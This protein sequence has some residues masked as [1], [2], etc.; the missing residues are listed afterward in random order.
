MG[1]K[2]DKKKGKVDVTIQNREVVYGDT[3]PNSK[4]RKAAIQHM[5]KHYTGGR[6]VKAYVKGKMPELNENVIVNYLIA[7]EFATSESSAILIMRHMSDE[8][9]AHVICES[10]GNPDSAA[11]AVALEKWRKSIEAG[12]KEARAKVEPTSTKR[13]KPTKR[14][15]QLSKVQ[16]R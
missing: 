12:E 8:W 4:A 3:P 13:Y 16:I 6:A 11:M 14:I 10:S 7:E 5:L 1:K 9:L 15:T 2:K